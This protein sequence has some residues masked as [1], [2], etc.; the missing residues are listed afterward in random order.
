MPISTLIAC[1]IITIL[2]VAC[3]ALFVSLRNA[4]GSDRSAE[5][6]AELKEAK[7]Q[8]GEKAEEVARLSERLA[9]MNDAEKKRKEE[10]AEAAKTQKELIESNIR[11]IAEELLKEKSKE[12]EDVSEKKWD[13]L[14]SP[15]KEKLEE[16]KSAVK[17]QQRQ[18]TE[19]RLSIEKAIESMG[20]QTASVSEQANNLAEALKGKSNKILGNWGEKI[21]KTVL[22]N[23]GLVEGEK[24]DFVAQGM[25]RDEFG[26]AVQSNETNKNRKLIPDVLLYLPENK[27]VVIDSKASVKDYADYM[28]AKDDAE[29]QDALKKHLEAIKNHAKGLSAK[30]YERYI[31]KTGR[32]AL[33]YVI[34]FVPNEGAYQLYFTE[35]HAE[36]HEFFEKGIIITSE[37]N[38]FAML[39]IIRTAWAQVES[40]KNMEKAKELMEDAVLRIG[41]FMAKFADINKKIVSLEKSY[42]DANAYL[43]TN[44]E[45]SVYAAVGE[46]VET[47]VISEKVAAPFKRKIALDSN[48]DTAQTENAESPQIPH[49]P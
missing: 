47:S 41:Q 44:P 17:D 8:L 21:L 23:A 46:L 19:D 29:R 45:A 3:G 4:K 48:S 35:R 2:A 34:M 20:K 15:L 5:L 12:L 36:W 16:F 6:Q 49:Q 11:N 25:L 28:A 22:E 33:P 37:S 40:Q 7:A 30:N 9:A 10:Q 42:A 18:G 39:R 24:F 38:L 31:K 1:A 26:N 32:D 14:L 13:G 43:L 27:A